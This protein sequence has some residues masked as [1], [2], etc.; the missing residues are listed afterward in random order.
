MFEI[1]DTDET[2]SN[3]FVDSDE[4]WELM[5]PQTTLIVVDTSDASRVIDAAILSKANKKS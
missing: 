5:T 4:A 3:V 2:L 1:N